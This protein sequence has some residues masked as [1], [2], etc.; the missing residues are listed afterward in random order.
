MSDAL[1]ISINLI[2]LLINR[3]VRYVTDA[4]HPGE[5]QAEQ[6]RGFNCNEAYAD[7]KVISLA[8]AFD[9]TK[10]C[11]SVGCASTAFARG[12]LGESSPRLHQDGACRNSTAVEGWPCGGSV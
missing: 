6:S 1:T 12:Y 2:L 10:T 9:A 5:P 7:P 3:T 8:V 4:G 11:S